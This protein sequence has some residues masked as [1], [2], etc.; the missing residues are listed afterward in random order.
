LSEVFLNSEVL[1]NNSKIL[2]R[3]CK[4]EKV[5]WFFHTFLLFAE[6]KIDFKYGE[7]FLNCFRSFC[8]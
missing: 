8:I 7:I 4:K 2:Q 6:T 3:A 5:V 1:L